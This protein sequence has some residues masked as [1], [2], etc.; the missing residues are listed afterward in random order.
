MIELP[1]VSIIIPNYNGEKTIKDC[2]QS[3]YLLDYSKFEVILVDD[4]SM[5]NSISVIHEFSHRLRIIKNTVNRGFARTINRG[6]RES[7]G[8]VVVLLNMDTVVKK[9]WLSELVK[10]LISDE[11]I[12]IVGSKILDPDDKTIQH[13]GGLIRDNAL[14][15]H[16]GRG[17]IDNGQYNR[18][19]EV[20]Y[21]CGASLGF[22]KSLLRDI[23]YLEED[24]SPLYY[25]DT[26]LAFRARKKGYK[27][28]YVPDSI[29]VHNENFSTGGLTAK[30]YYFYHKSRIR[31]ALKNYSPKYLFR[32]FL[33]AEI[34]WFKAFQPKEF[35][36]QL[37]KA[38]FVNFLSLPRL[39]LFRYLITLR[40]LD[41]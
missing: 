9:D 36:I 29:L 34:I 27:V 16:I 6:I 41:N 26:D 22:R 4:A 40:R 14:T 21:I 3:I 5:D 1:L 32:G 38:Y 28:V 30:F 18:I 19:R 17:E 23:G 20:D 12:A 35:K 13:A 31:F 10:V 37:I 7:K 8:E 24:Y 39:V 33:K 11:R 25:E 15:V 2:L